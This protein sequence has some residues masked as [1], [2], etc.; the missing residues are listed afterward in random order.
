MTDSAANPTDIAICRLLAAGPL[1]TAALAER[2]AIP[3]R[4]TRHR[5][6]RLR[7]AGAV[8]TGIDGLHHLAVPVLAG[9]ITGDLPALAAPAGDLAVPVLAAPIAGG[10]PSRDRTATTASIAG[11]LP[12][13]DTT[14]MPLAASVMMPDHPDRDG[15]SPRQGSGWGPGV[16]LA[17]IAFGV[18]AAGGIAIAVAIHRRA[19]PASPPLSPAP[20]RSMGFGYP[21][22]PWG[23]RP[24]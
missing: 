13:R 20:A 7:Q 4:T 19:L 17:A 8:I 24:W 10:L 6:Y 2:L 3:E 12:A 22:D 11:G 16:V 9:S 1:P 15:E 21:G 23:G 14:A 5:V 18:A